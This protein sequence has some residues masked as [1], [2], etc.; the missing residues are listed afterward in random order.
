MRH[1][2]AGDYKTAIRKYADWLMPLIGPMMDASADKMGGDQP[3]RGAGEAI[4]T[5]LSLFGPKALETARIKVPAVASTRNPVEAAAVKFG[6]QQGVPIDAATATGNPFIRNI[7]K[8]TANTP[9]GVRPAMRTHAAQSAALER[10]GADLATQARGAASTPETAG[11]GIN[12]VLQSKIEAHAQYAEHAYGGLDKI[13]ADPK[14]TVKVTV[15]TKQVPTG[16]MD[17]QGYPTYRD[18]P[19]VQK[20]AIPVDLRG[21]RASLKP[22]Y[23]SIARSLPVTQRQASA[24]FQALE[25]IVNGQDYAPLLQT[26]AI[27]VR[28][29]RSPAG[30]T[31]QNFGRSVRDL[32]RKG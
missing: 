3:W 14:N 18:M 7:Q 32:A 25:N 22:I 11:V 8:A 4:G 13:A 29:R 28:S 15:S 12:D 5:G 20:I 26:N 10:V 30:P 19:I 9:L 31:S 24:G 16:E 23:D 6:E 17:A 27:W 2:Q 1:G 21:V